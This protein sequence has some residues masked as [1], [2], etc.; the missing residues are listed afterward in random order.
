MQAI[1]QPKDPN[2]EKAGEHQVAELEEN[3]AQPRAPVGQPSLRRKQV[4]LHRQRREDDAQPPRPMAMRQRSRLAATA[5]A[6]CGR[7]CHLR[8]AAISAMPPTK[9]NAIR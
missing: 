2:D 9:G 3:K 1:D 8:C 6:Q 5:S 7:Q 4:G